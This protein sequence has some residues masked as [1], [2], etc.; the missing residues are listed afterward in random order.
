MTIRKVKEGYR[1]E[2]HTGKNLGT[3]DTRG[4]AEQRERQV[5][6]FKHKGWK[7]AREKRA[8]SFNL[9]ELNTRWTCW[10][11]WFWSSIC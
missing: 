4:G 2:S 5:Q 3:Y 7:K 10:L 9:A 6:Y 8:S 1:L 11:I